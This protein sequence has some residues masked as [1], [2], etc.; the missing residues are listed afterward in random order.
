MHNSILVL[1]T[2]NL[3]ITAYN[4][5]ALTQ[6]LFLKMIR[7]KERRLLEK[8]RNVAAFITFRYVSI[9]RKDPETFTGCAPVCTSP[10]GRQWWRHPVM[11]WHFFRVIILKVGFRVR[12]TSFWRFGLFS[13][14]LW[15]NCSICNYLNKVKNVYKVRFV[16]KFFLSSWIRFLAVFGP[17]HLN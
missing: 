13:F 9:R 15:Y 3:A 12:S 8:F 16:E 14:V 10:R 7:L 1:N 5:C 11:L 4:Q 2:Y 17:A 6:C